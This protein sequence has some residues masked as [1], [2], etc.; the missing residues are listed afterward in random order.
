MDSPDVD[1]PRNWKADKHTRDAQ[2]EPLS[3][4]CL[5]PSHIY[6]RDVR[7]LFEEVADLKSPLVE[8]T[9]VY[10][11]FAGRQTALLLQ[12]RSH[13]PHSPATHS[14]H[15]PEAT[16]HVLDVCPYNSANRTI[17]LSTVIRVGAPA[18]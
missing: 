9:C 11:S 4:Q 18:P 8:A 3:I 7:A 10:M 14:F 13:V 1:A 16:S 15:L 2:P 6:Y 12:V 17:L 5:T